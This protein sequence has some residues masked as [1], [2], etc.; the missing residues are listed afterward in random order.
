[1]QER[2][3]YFKVAGE[4]SRETAITLVQKLEE[5][6]GHRHRVEAE[7]GT[8]RQMETKSIDALALTALVIAVPSAVLACADLVERLRKKKKLDD[9]L[10]WAQ[11]QPGEVT[12][13]TPE[14][15]V[16]QLHNASS[17]MILDNA[18]KVLQET[19]EKE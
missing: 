16:I 3:F 11:N 7:P 12:V 10:K 18:D 15:T 6:F 8:G 1:M 2:N 4:Q 5:E 17:G 9:I 14:G 13:I 19:G